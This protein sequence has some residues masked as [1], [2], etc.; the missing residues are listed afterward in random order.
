MEEAESTHLQVKQP[1]LTLWDP[2]LAILWRG[3]GQHSRV[4][5]SDETGAS[6]SC[7]R[8]K[9]WV[10]ADVWCLRRPA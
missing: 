5:Q 8:V 6:P 9:V 4:I 2:F 1:V 10:L 7:G 3:S